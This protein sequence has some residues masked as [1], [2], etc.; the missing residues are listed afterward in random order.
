MPMEIFSSKLNALLNRAAAR[1]LYDIYNMIHYGLFD[2]S[3]YESFRKSVVFYTAI[4][5][6]KIPSEYDTS[7]IDAITTRKIR[8]D[9]LPVIRKGEFVELSAM[10][11]I[12][13]NYIEKLLVLTE[14]EKA[15]LK[16]FSEKQYQP[17]LLFD[18]KE[19]LNRISNHPMAIWKMQEHG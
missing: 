11:R 3:E 4:S 19:I 18:D 1:D 6:E 10:K 14:N 13:K 17:E 8:T 12:V 15:F 2:E 16:A 9:L 5:Q 7:R